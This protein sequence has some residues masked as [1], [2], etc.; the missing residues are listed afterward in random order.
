MDP[1]TKRNQAE[2]VRKHLSRHLAPIGFSRT[3]PT[4]WTRA[5]SIIVPFVHL[6]LLTFTSGFRVHFGLRVLNDTFPAP[7]LN[8]P[9]SE[10]SW[11]QADRKY[12]FHFSATHDSVVLCANEL[13]SYIAEAGLPW[14]ERFASPEGALTPNGPLTEDSKARLR[15]AL[16]GGPDRAAVAASRA[17]LGIST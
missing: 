14:F 16:G 4:F 2:A 5:D 8:G 3:K 13:A 15:L 1:K 7:A 9:M 6:H 10:G 12:Q 11:A 17:M